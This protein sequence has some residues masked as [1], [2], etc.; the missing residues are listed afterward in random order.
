[1]RNLF[2]IVSFG[3]VAVAMTSLVASYWIAV[4][5]NKAATRPNFQRR[6]FNRFL[7]DQLLSEN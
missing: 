1:M 2:K 6:S 5:A 4:A 3:V 7:I